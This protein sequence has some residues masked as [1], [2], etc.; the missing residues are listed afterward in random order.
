MERE[1]EE[2]ILDANKVDLKNAKENGMT[3]AM[4]DRLSLSHE[5]IASIADSIL[6]IAGLEDPLGNGITFTK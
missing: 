3:D 5:R 2:Y 6:K 4:L 1:K